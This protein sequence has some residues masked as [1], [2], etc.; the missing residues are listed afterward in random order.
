MPLLDDI[1]SKCA[2]LPQKDQK[3]VKKFIESRSFD[4]LLEIID[5]DIKKHNR[6]RNA[7]GIF[8]NEEDAILDEEYCDLYG[9]VVTYL[10]CIDPDYDE[11]DLILE[12]Y[13]W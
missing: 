3:Y 5:S 1:K 8:E 9:D 10:R 4:K 11:N 7:D 12:D 6:K 13:D 2:I